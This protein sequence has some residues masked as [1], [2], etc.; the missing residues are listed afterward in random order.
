MTGSKDD[1]EFELTVNGKRLTVS[2]APVGAS[3][4]SVLRDNLGL[5]G[6]KGACEEGECGS[7]SVML[8]GNLVCACLVMASTVTEA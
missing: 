6:T 5:T 7:C 3:L 8:D 4:L 1:R 2:G